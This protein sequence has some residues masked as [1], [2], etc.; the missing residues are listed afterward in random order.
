MGEKDH[1][2]YCSQ[3]SGRAKERES[4]SDVLPAEGAHRAHWSGAALGT[5]DLG[6]LVPRGRSLV[7]GVLGSHDA[8]KTTLLVGTYL[9]CLRGREI[10]AAKFAG[11]RTL[12]AWEALAA[13]SRNEDAAR[14]PSFPPH[15]PRGTFRVPGLLHLALR[16]RGG[17]LR[18]ILLTDAPGEW[19]TRWSINEDAPEAE[20]AR[21]VVTHA[22]AFLLVID[23]KRLAGDERGDARKDAR[24]LIERLSGHVAGRP[25]YLVWA[26]S[27]IAPA[28]RIRDTIRHTLGVAI[29]HAFEVESTTDR[30]ES[31]A[32]VVEAS[33]QA[34]WT[35]ALARLIVP[36]TV[37]S[38][39]FAA[40][41]GF[42]AQ[43]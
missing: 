23:C 8:G 43:S 26:K 34:A 42:N 36:P 16:D 18:D 33:V 20:G 32:A 9:A 35:P 28:P 10:A 37:N 27:D 13:W 5:M 14:A 21:W 24:Q 38:T 19:F 25:T 22:D 31:L 6:S 39:P 7:V 15:T 30:P 12:G 3:W 29:P 17:E 4:E 2:K 41:R 11:S 1:T 40:F